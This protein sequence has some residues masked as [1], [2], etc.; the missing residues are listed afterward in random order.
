[1][2]Q[3][4]HDGEVV[5]ADEHVARADR[6][7]EVDDGAVP[8]VVIVVADLAGRSFDLAQQFGDAVQRDQGGMGQE[9]GAVGSTGFSYKIAPERAFAAYSLSSDRR[10]GCRARK[11]VTMSS[12]SRR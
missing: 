3:A 2:L 7:P 10:P 1:M 11:S 4:G 9:R 12:T 6:L 5:A 8:F